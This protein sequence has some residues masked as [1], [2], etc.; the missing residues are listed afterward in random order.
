MG[1]QTASAWKRPAA[2]LCGR[3]NVG[4]ER[5]SDLLELTQRFESRNKFDESCPGLP[6]GDWGSGCVRLAS[7]QVARSRGRSRARGSLT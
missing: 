2:T 4:P 1:L 7:L 5:E 6:P 3:G